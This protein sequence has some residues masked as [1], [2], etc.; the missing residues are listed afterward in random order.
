MIILCGSINKSLTLQQYEKDGNKIRY[1][2]LLV[3]SLIRSIACMVFSLP[4][5]TPPCSFLPKRG[6]HYDAY[7]Q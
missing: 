5:F 6:L 7:Q 1:I 4:S 3:F 2:G